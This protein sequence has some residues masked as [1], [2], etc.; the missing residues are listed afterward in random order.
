MELCNR[1][2]LRFSAIG[3]SGSFRTGLFAALD[4]WGFGLFSMTCWVRSSHREEGSRVPAVRLRGGIVRTCE[5]S[6]GNSIPPSLLTPSLLYRGSF[7]ISGV[8]IRKKG[9]KWLDRLGENFLEKSGTRGGPGAG[10]GFRLTNRIRVSYYPVM[11][12]LAY[13][14][15]SS[16]LA[17][18]C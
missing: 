14:S 18:L 17:R 16:P 2:L 9:G 4:I 15:L 6:D 11:N 10:F 7:Q 1:Q 3:K 8:K 13:P 12:S 5:V